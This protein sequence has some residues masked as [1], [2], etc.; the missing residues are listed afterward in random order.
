MALSAGLET[1]PTLPQ[2]GHSR[3]SQIKPFLAISREKWRQLT[4]EG[5]APKPIRM[6]ERCTVYL[7]SE[8]RRFIEDP[9]GYRVE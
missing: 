9:L 1:A 2:I 5:R 8:V 3:W 6:G 7:N 4:I